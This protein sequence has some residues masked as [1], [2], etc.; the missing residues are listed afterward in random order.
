VNDI[1]ALFALAVGAACGAALVVGAIRDAQRT[2]AARKAYYAAL[3]RYAASRTALR[4]AE[5][6]KADEIAATE[7]RRRER[8]ELRLFHA[9][10]ARKLKSITPDVYRKFNRKAGES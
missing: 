7:A 5:A 1:L 9:E 4:R 3:S 2:R 6:R 10:S 8:E